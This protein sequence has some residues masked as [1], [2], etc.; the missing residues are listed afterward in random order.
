M[1]EQD[2]LTDVPPNNSNSGTKIISARKKR[3]HYDNFGTL[4]PEDDQIAINESLGAGFKKLIYYKE[5]KV[6][7]E[8]RY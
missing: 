3:K 7:S 4:I 2:V 5:D 8:T 6:D 1:K